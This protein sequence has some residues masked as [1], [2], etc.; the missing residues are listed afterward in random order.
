[1]TCI[2]RNEPLKNHTYYRIGGPAK[3]FARP[4]SLEDLLEISG[5]LARE[6]LRYFILGAGSNVLFDD[7]GFDGLVIQTTKLNDHLER[8]DNLVLAGC[9]VLNIKMLRLCMQEGLKGL[10]FL[11]GIPG[12]V[13][14]AVFMNAGTHLG[15]SMKA[16]REVKAY[17]L[18]TNHIEVYSNEKLSFTY[19]SQKFLDPHEIILSAIFEIEIGEPLEVQKEIQSLLERRKKAQ[20]IDKPSC[21]SVFK[22]PAPNQNAWKLISDA[23]LRG[24]R[25]GDAQIS[26][27]HTNFIVNNGNA[28]SKDVRSLIELAKRT[29][30][31]KFGVMLQEEVKIVPMNGGRTIGEH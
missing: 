7:E 15:E 6:K 22:N 26:E 27:M 8:K 14:G 29:V 4:R 21:G 3:F 24:H 20:P 1:M 23:G 16:I 31:E 28:R 18:R 25:I 17:N 11:V 12:N 10:E 30:A 2:T 9:S 19:R 13:G 5:L